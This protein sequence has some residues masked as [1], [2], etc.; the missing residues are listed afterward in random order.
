M[1]IMTMKMKTLIVGICLFCF[2][3]NASPVRTH[4][5]ELGEWTQDIDAAREL[6]KKEN[7]YLFINFTGSDWCG[8][9]QLMD[10]HV[11][12]QP[13]WKEFAA[14]RLALAFIDSPRDPS[15]VPEEYR[16]RNRKLRKQYGVRGYPT[17]IIC[18][19][20][21]HLAGELGAIKSGTEYNFVTNVTAVLVEDRLPRY[22]SETEMAEY[23]E[24]QKE[25]A[26]WEATNQLVQA[27]FRDKYAVARQRAID[28]IDRVKLDVLRK[29]AEK[30]R[31]GMTP[32]E[33]AKDAKIVFA[34]SGRGVLHEGA[35]FGQWTADFEAAKAL[36]KKSGKDMLV[37][38][39]GHGWCKWGDD[40]ERDVFNTDEWM[41]FA[42]EHFVLVYV[43]CPDEKSEGRLP[44][45]I[46]ERNAALYKRYALP[47]CPFFLLTDADGN[48]Y[49][50]FGATSGITPA[51]QIEAVEFLLARKNLKSLVS[52]EDYATYAA[53]VAREK[54]VSS[55]WRKAYDEFIE[56]MDRQVK[57]FEPIAEKRN[58]IFKKGM[59]AYLRE[60]F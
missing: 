22:V 49:D 28:E 51:E 56:E 59:D 21:G 34:D 27:Q 5:A 25:K 54:E 1:E 3:A 15:L 11:F 2:A 41:N 12:T 48:R 8:W 16:S 52:E 6:A 53:A 60:N 39:V 13:G 40:M 45:A 47:G 36:A 30:L 17:F 46:L 24:A 57:A 7:K 35:V 14:K 31:Q 50:A 23:R 55:A 43:D 18:G 10:E 33:A 37:A 29:G 58:R 26:S 4:G 38:F 19:P 44:E 42:K 9:C 32:N 20:D